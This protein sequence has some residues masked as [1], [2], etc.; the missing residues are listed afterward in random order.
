VVR[1]RDVRLVAPFLIPTRSAPK[2]AG[3]GTEDT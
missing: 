1:P 2:S 3:G